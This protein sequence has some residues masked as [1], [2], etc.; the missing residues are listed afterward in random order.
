MYIRYRTAHLVTWKGTYLAHQAQNILVNGIVFLCPLDSSLELHSQ[1]F[2]MLPQPP[3]N[4][5]YKIT[6]IIRMIKGKRLFFYHWG[7]MEYNLPFKYNLQNP[8][9][10]TCRV[11]PHPLPPR[12]LKTR[13]HQLLALSPAS[14][15]QWI[16]DCC[17]APMP[18]T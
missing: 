10:N 12:L 16:L 3:D 14:R 11:I 1:D 6:E 13:T 7:H 17:P 8:L 9:Y 18:I 2:W 5:K 15:V 4:F